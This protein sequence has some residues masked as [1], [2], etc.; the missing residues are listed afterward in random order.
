ML[1]ENH[2]N[3]DGRLTFAAEIM[4]G[5]RPFMTHCHK[6]MEIILVLRGQVIIKN[7]DQVYTLQEG[8]VWMAAPFASHSIE[9]ATP[10]SKRLA[11]LLDLQIMGAWMRRGEEHQDAS[12]LL[13]AT[14]LYCG[15]WPEATTPQV[16]QCIEDMYRE[17]KTQENG[18]ELAVKIGVNRLVLMAMREMPRRPAGVSNR[19][20]EKLK[21]ILEYVALHY[22]SDI[23]LEAC[24]GQVGFNA[25]YLSR[26]FKAHMG[27]TFQEYV[28][29]LRIDRARWLLR[30][31][32]LPVTE[33]G[34]L[35]G[36]K[37]IKTFNKLF[38]NECQMTPT[39]YRRLNES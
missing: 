22:C 38:K 31:E 23:S 29:Q 24:A 25:S 26:Y 2:Y 15:H 28:K 34:Y 5:G 30:N 12:K 21:D 7:D 36:F 27:V 4:G 6:E 16:R 19:S 18:W 13:E 17:Y 11:M 9:S 1:Y 14:D 37:D 3:D 20:M 35:S 10:D 8:D 32:R 33:V 39:Q